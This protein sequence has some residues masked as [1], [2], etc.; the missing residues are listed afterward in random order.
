MSVLLRIETVE[1]DQRAARRR[2]S[3]APIDDVCR[4]C[5]T[6]PVSRRHR[7]STE[8]QL[9][10]AIGVR[11]ARA[12]ER[13][14]AVPSLRPARAHRPLD[15]TAPPSDRRK[16]LQGVKHC[17][18]RPARRST[19]RADERLRQRVRPIVNDR[20]SHWIHV[21]D[22][23]HSRA[24]SKWWLVPSGT[25]ASRSRRASHAEHRG[26]LSLHLSK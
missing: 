10:G 12:A 5:R 24:S 20:N 17:R 15:A 22:Y 9:P 13:V 21:P 4:S 16:P 23:D 19:M 6:R 18:R 1:V 3:H 8:G 14:N 26:I 2:R 7:T 25:N 11:S